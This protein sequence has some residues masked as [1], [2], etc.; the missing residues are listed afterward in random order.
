MKLD[1]M[2]SLI[3]LLILSLRFLLVFYLFDFSIRI[4]RHIL[5]LSINISYKKTGDYSN[6]NSLAISIMYIDVF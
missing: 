6:N 5:L 3:H 1:Q 4:I 2:K